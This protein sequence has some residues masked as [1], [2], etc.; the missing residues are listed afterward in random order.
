MFIHVVSIQVAFFHENTHI[1][2]FHLMQAGHPDTEDAA[3]KL[4]EQLKQL[5][6]TAEADAIRQQYRVA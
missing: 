2:L 5:G 3:Q 4:A 6:K 1:V